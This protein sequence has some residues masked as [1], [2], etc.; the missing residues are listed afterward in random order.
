MNARSRTSHKL[1]AVSLARGG[2]TASFRVRP[3][4]TVLGDLLVSMGFA[5][6]GGCFGRSFADSP[7]VPRLFE[8]FAAQIDEMI[9]HKRCETSAP[10]EHALQVVV[11]RLSG[12][13]DWWLSGS[14]ALAIRGI[15]AKPRDLDLVVDDAERTGKLLEDILIEPVTRMKGW[16]A[17][18][19]GRAF[20]QALIEWVSRMHSEVD[21]TG[22]H[23]QGPEAASRRE[24]VVWQGHKILCSPLDL[25]LAV[26]EARGMKDRAR[27]IRSFIARTPK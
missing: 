10:W 2:S 22:R 6:E 26:A 16:V 12:Q 9:R 11:D 19:H 1:V 24:Q 14:A 17:D 18:W 3:S 27:A 25:Q 4:E 20:E 15:N 5:R 23:E 21:R 13:V 7:D 8:N